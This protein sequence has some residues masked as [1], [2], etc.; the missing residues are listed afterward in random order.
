L[1]PDSA[2]YTPR[3]HQRA[4]RDQRQHVRIEDHGQFALY[5]VSHRPPSVRYNANFSHLRTKRRRGGE[6]WFGGLS[7]APVRK[8]ML[9]SRASRG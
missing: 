5:E 4:N 2:G 3:D 7:V 9:D 1:A 8:D 6:P